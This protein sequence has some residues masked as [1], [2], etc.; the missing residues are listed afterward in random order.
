MQKE[1]YRQFYQF[2]AEIYAVDDASADAEII[3]LT[4]RLWRQLGLSRLELQLNSLGSREEQSAYRKHLRDYFEAHYQ[5]LDEDSQRRLKSNPLRI[6]DSKNP[7]MQSLI[8]AAPVP[9]DHLGA[10]SRSHFETVQEILRQC[11]QTF[12]V[13]QRLVRGLDYYT[14]TVFEWVSEDLGAQNAVCGGGRYDQLFSELGGQQTGAVGFSAGIERIIAV[15]EAQKIAAPN[16]LPHIYLAAVG[17]APG[18]AAHAIAESLRNA[19]P[20]LHLQVDAGPSSFKAK[21]RRADRSGARFALILGEDELNE[22]IVQLNHLRASQQ[23]SIGLDTLARH[24]ETL[25]QTPDGAC[26]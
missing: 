7:R 8:D 22:H 18:A 23:E 10:A 21:L 26:G 5:E 13:N 12:T 16:P 25:L 17:T 3:L 15:M 11:G 19:L 9:L 24:I 1:R 20:D 2:G 6:L 14:R 4:A